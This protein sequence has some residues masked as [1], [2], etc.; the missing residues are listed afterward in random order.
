MPLS[1][2]ARYD[3]PVDGGPT[4]ILRS[5][6]VS[7]GLVPARDTT[8]IRLAGPVRFGN[9]PALGT[10]SAGVSWVNKDHGN[11]SETRLVRD[12]QLQLRE[13]PAMQNGPLFA[14]SPDPVTDTAQFFKSNTSPGAFSLGHD[15]LRNAVVGVSGEPSFTTGKTF[16]FPLRRARLLGLQFASEFA[17]SEPHVV[18]AVASDR[19]TIRISGYMDDAQVNAKKVI[20]F[21]DCRI[22]GVAN[23]G[24]VELSTV[25]DKVRLTLSVLQ[26]RELLR[27]T[28][29]RNLQ[30][31]GCGPDAYDCVI[32]IPSQDSVV[33][34]DGSVG[35]ERALNLLVD[36]VG[37]GNFA[38][39]PDEDLSRKAKLCLRFVVGNLL[40]AELLKCSRLPCQSRHPVGATVCA[41]HRIAECGSLLWR[42]LQ[43]HFGGELHR[44]QYTT[45]V[46]IGQNTKGSGNSEN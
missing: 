45:D 18:D 39:Q 31:A 27:T 25:E 11:T 38:D 7:V 21:L 10:R 44:F 26:Q 14:P 12:E 29:E 20:N 5:V 9:V 43:F 42:W 1:S 13:R 41:L 36:L 2:T 3:W 35:P 46:P 37:V 16:Q 24:K 30:A 19:L 28:H 8:E 32:H 34:W 40:K 15:L 22:V 6:K 33:V 17:V 23:G 4:D